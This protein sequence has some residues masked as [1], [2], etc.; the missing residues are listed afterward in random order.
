MPTFETETFRGSWEHT[1][2]P[3]AYSEGPEP[4][5]LVKSGVGVEATCKECGSSAVVAVAT[6]QVQLECRHCDRT[7]FVDRAKLDHGSA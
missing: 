6:G 5:A 2:R 3:R 7:E 1:Y 4:R